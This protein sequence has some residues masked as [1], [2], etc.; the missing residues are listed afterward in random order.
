M[1]EAVSGDEDVLHS[2]TVQ[3]AEV[4]LWRDRERLSY[5]EKRLIICFLKGR[6]SA[7]SFGKVRI[8][9]EDVVELVL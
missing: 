9:F 5:S 4:M 6:N 8:K 2:H 7:H 3:I 1:Q